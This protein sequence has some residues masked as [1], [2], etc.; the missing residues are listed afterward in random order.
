MD[1]VTQAVLGAGIA[2]AMMGRRYG[3]KALVAGA[4]LATLPDLDVVID[5]GNPLAQMI[6]HR[7]FSHSLFVLTAFALLLAWLARRFRLHK[8]GNDYGRLTL[9]LWLILITHP[10]LDAF[11][12]YGTQLWWPL[13]PTPASWSS[14]FIIDPFYTLPLLAGVVAG[15]VMGMRPATCRA[16]AW[17]LVVGA[18]YLL[19]SLGA[20]HW[21]E[22]RVHA[23]LTQQG[24]TPVAMFSVPQ[25]F[26]IVLWRVVA[27]ME[28][29]NYV[30]AVT[31]M[32]DPDERE[33]EFIAFPSNA[34]LGEALTPQ[35]WLDGLRW[36]T[37]DWLR[38]DDIGGK[39]VVSDLR[40]G[41]GTGH[42]S[43]RFLVG[44]RDPHTGEW[45]AVTPEYWQGGPA[46]RD[47][48][49]L[50]ATLQRVWETGSPLPLAMW[51]QRMTQP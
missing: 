16:L 49:A 25:P 1:S 34:E 38:Y 50:S 28:D 12:S 35:T 15:F 26:N 22:Q 44:E 43:F 3:R 14:V 23:M 5:Y 30:E 21:A 6:N 45:Q 17:L 29:G 40:M 27:R 46:R 36:F 47:M 8:D 11:T 19:A 13:R 41:I 10:I 51:N 2:G 32:L 7:G 37:G 4:V 24:R 48:A 33:P 9:T 39:L 31:G 18:S 20:K 42:Y